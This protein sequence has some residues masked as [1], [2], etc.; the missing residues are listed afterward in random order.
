[1]YT[2]YEPSLRA[3]T[4]YGQ[5]TDTRDFACVNYGFFQIP[6]NTIFSG[7]KRVQSLIQLHS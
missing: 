6:R 5:L 2:K 3:E 1:M 7:I 4:S